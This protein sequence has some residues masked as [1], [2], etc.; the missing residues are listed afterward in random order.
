MKSHLLVVA[1]FAAIGLAG[2]GENRAETG[3]KTAT[4]PATTGA[5]APAQP[6]PDATTGATTYAPPPQAPAAGTQPGA[7]QAPAAAQPAAPATREQKGPEK[8]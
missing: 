2:C 8:K 5:P 1:T 7:Q 4:P 3:S 6:T